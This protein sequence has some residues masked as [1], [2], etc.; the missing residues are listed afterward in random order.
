VGRGTYRLDLGAMFC[1]MFMNW[2]DMAGNVLRFRV[3]EAMR[4]EKKMTKTARD[5]VELEN[6]NWEGAVCM[7]G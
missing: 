6:V 2:A 7:V 4:I 3:W 1:N 5:V